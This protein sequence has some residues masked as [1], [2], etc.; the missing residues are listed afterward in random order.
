MPKID[1]IKNEE[2][3]RLLDAHV[4]LFPKYTTQLMNLANQNSQGTR[5]QVVGQMSDLIQLFPGVNLQEW[6]E[7][8]LNQNP[9]AIED[10]TNR[11]YSMVSSFQEAIKLIDKDMVRQWVADLVITKTFAGLKVQ[12]VILKHLGNKF[13]RS[14]R[15]ATPAEESQNV[16][17]VIGS[18]LV[19]IKPITFKTMLTLPI[20]IKVHE[21]YY[22]KTKEGLVIEY[23]DSLE[24]ALCH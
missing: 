14:Y 21:I 15:T 5:P 10:A 16:D 12:G 8:Y 1:K 13:N 2:L 7:W 22:N 9:N 20:E 4:P 19:S 3:F 24:E 18:A 23:A 17:G 11:I 6:E